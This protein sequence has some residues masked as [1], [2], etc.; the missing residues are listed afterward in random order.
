MHELE[1]GSALFDDRNLDGHDGLF[2]ASVKSKIPREWY[3]FQKE[4]VEASSDQGKLHPTQVPS[5]KGAKLPKRHRRHSTCHL[6]MG[7]A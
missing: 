6:C 7:S 5:S 4:R 2:E 1:L 3:E